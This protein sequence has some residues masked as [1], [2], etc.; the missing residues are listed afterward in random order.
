MLQG[1]L[2]ESMKSVRESDK[3]IEAYIEGLIKYGKSKAFFEDLDVRYVRNRIL[4][5]LNYHD[6]KEPTEKVD[7]AESIEELLDGILKWSYD[8]GLIKENTSLYRD[9]LDSALMGAMLPRPSEVIR[10]FK[11]RY[12][13]SP[14]EATNYLYN[15]SIDSNYIR[16]S[17]T[18]KN[19]KWVYESEYGSIEITINVSK[20]EKDVKEIEAERN[21]PKTGYPKCL[22]CPENEGYGGRLNHPARQNLRIIPLDLGGEQWFL[23][24]SPYLYYNEHCILLNEDHKPMS[25]DRRTLVK[26]MDFLVKLPHYFVGSNA[27]LP[28]VGGSILSHDH[29]QGGR[30]LFPMEEAEEIRTF[31]IPGFSQ[32]RASILKW[33]LSVIR[34]KSEDKDSLIELGDKVITYW[35]SYR[36]ESLGIIPYTK[37]EPHSTITPIARFKDGSYE[38]DL[39]LR[40]NRRDESYPLGIFHPHEDVHNIKKENIGLIEVMGLAVLPARLLTETKLI[41]KYLL[42]YPLTQG[43][44]EIIGKHMDLCKEILSREDSINQSNVENIVKEVIGEKFVLALKDAGVF[45]EDPEG[46]RGFLQFIESL[47]WQQSY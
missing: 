4:E 46:Q 18:D 16:K 43:E 2:M 3:V 32:V 27:D 9:L 37:D 33:P 12:N 20:P 11:D 19:L 10:E 24:Y 26:M 5:I 17:R 6:Y 21:T 23:Q 13:K 30:H 1:F 15:L 42:K 7:R 14:E 34:L 22:L 35:R 36:D 40:N 39:V 31:K 41:E 47:G 25:I 29:F 44:R 28:V 45:K 8:N 38:L